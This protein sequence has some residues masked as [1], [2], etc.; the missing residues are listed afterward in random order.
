METE[1]QNLNSE[2]QRLK[3]ENEELRSRLNNSQNE[4]SVGSESKQGSESN[5]SGDS[6]SKVEIP[7]AEPGPLKGL[8]NSIFG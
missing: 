5:K 8:I 2:N 7:E 1:V 3:K 6:N 4:Q